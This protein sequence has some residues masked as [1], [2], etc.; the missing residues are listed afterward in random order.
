MHGEYVVT[1]MPVLGCLSACIAGC[2]Q[3]RVV[4]A[5]LGCV[6]TYLIHVVDLGPHQATSKISMHYDIS[7][8][9]YSVP[10][11]MAVLPNICP[12]GHPVDQRPS[13]TTR[14]TWHLRST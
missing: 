9:S 1:D 12:A 3:T 10:Y 5:S 11:R 6:I 7:I 8:C 14:L 4:R 13:Q 2:V